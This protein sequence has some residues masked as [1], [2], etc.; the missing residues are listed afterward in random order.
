LVFGGRRGKNPRNPRNQNK[1]GE[2]N[3]Y[4]PLTASEERCEKVLCVVVPRHLGKRRRD[5]AALSRVKEK[6]RE[7]GDEE[8]SL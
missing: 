6:K 2:K 5:I 4:A 8:S 3:W 1:K 7:K